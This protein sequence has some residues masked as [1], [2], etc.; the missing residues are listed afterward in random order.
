MLT[1]KASLGNLQS[2]GLNGGRFDHL[3]LVTTDV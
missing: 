2:R 3:R 1:K